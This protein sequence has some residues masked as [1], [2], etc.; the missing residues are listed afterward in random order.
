MANLLLR[1]LT[2]ERKVEREYWLADIFTAIG[3]D[4]IKII[5]QDKGVWNW[6][7][8]SFID[9]FQIWVPHAIKRCI[10]LNHGHYVALMFVADVKGEVTVHAYDSKFH[11]SHFDFLTEFAND[12][13]IKFSNVIYEKVEQQLDSVS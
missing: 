9:E 2:Y 4:D 11:A 3:D 5:H 8:D 7:L 1:A 12:L 6:T 13:G 10:V